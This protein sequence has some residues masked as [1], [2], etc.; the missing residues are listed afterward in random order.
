VVN[1]LEAG[2][3]AAAGAVITAE[4]QSIDQRLRHR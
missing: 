3:Q 4:P 2:W 1:V